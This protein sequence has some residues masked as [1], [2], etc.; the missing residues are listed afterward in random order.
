MAKGLPKD[1]M[2]KRALLYSDRASR[3]Q[4]NELA[5]AFIAEERYGEA[6]EFLE[7]TRDSG[8]LEAIRKIGLDTGDTFLLLRTEKITGEDLPAEKWR[9]TADR[10]KA[11]ERYY[12][13][14]RALERA[15][16]EEE[17]EALR[18]E[19]MPDY[20]PFRPEGK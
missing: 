6:L 10:A 3:E 15:G 13:A 7:L 12:D 17:A 11:G 14:Y 1:M 16:A 8:R 2:A 5:D 18:E 9:E 19:H 4:Q 20:R